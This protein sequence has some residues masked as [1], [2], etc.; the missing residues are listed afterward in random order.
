MDS[1]LASQSVSQPV[2][3]SAQPA[4]DQP[5]VAA[6]S[7]G[8]LAAAAALLP[9][10]STA[11]VAPPPSV[12]HLAFNGV[13]ATRRTRT[14]TS[15]RKWTLEWMTVCLSGL[16]W[17]DGWTGER[18]NERTNDDDRS[19][20][21]K[22]SISILWMKENEEM[23]NNGRAEEFSL[24][25]SNC[26]CTARDR[27]AGDGWGGGWGRLTCLDWRPEWCAN[28]D[29]GDDWWVKWTTRKWGELNSSLLQYGTPLIHSKSFE[30]EIH[31]SASSPW[32]DGGYQKQ[33]QQEGNWQLTVQVLLWREYSCMPPHNYIYPRA[34]IQE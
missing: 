3:Q 8:L 24:R 9:G 11:A 15:P 16:V 33:Q 12:H 7:F 2:I 13:D 31:Y 23:G 10:G 25:A 29:G 21:R 6:F 27:G 5:P 19:M 30:A 22:D 20:D 32:M 14:S 18:T 17:S 34:V 4:I 1:P 28:D 26:I